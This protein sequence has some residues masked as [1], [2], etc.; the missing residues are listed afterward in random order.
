MQI[1]QNNNSPQF[2]GSFLIN[3]KKAIPGIRE[4]FENAV[5]K[6]KVQIFDS[7][8]GKE[9][10]VMYV[11][12][13][14]KD[15]D[16]ACFILK[17][18]LN[19]RYYPE[20]STKLQ[21]SPNFPEEVS[22]YIKN[23]KPKLIQKHFELKEYADKFRAFCRQKRDSHLSFQDKI[24][25]SLKYDRA[26]CKKTKNA[27][28]IVTFEDGDSGNKVIMSPRNKNG[29]CFVMINP[30]NSY[31]SIKRYAF[32]MQGNLLATFEPPNGIKLFD[33]K[34]KEAIMYQCTDKK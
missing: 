14:S 5:G 31:D 28:S 27:N 3:Y 22:A 19:F 7:F 29:T 8:K 23:N 25:E 10:H 12:K 16:A 11:M 18:Q 24:L 9:N 13:D 32:D 30:K 15:Y 4:A 1:T 20:V 26:V 17:N 33:K 21:F 2:N 6:P 34:F